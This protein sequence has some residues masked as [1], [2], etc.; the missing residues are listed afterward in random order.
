[1]IDYTLIRSKRKTVA[2]HV[3]DGA[4]EVR[5]PLNLPKRDIDSFVA[6]KETWINGKLAI[7]R[8]QVER[9][10]SFALD[11]GSTVTLRGAEHPIAARDGTVAGFD[12]EVFYTPPGFNPEQIKSTCVE[13]YRLIAKALI[14]ARLSDYAPLMN[15]TPAAVKING[16]KSRWGSCSSKGNLN[17]SWRLIM[18]DDSVIDYVVVHELAHL[19]EMNHSARFWAVVAG[20]LPDYRERRA[21]LRE[22]QSKLGSEDW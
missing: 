2:I 18:A 14:N 16:A 22:L 5:A 11:Y 7:S 15:A 12:G 21:R 8:E 6:S 9:R 20:V 19:T 10:S 1:M 13:I 17:F 3:R 4:V